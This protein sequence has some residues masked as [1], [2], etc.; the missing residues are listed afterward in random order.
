MG[1]LDKIYVE[2]R[3]GGDQWEDILPYVQE[4]DH[5]LW[6]ATD[7][8]TAEHGHGGSDYVMLYRL[9]QSLR[10][11]TPSD[12]DV[13]DAAAWSV[14]APLS[15]RSVANRSCPVDFPDFTRGAWKTR[16]PLGIV[17]A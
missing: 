4:F 10:T 6:K 13:Y 17:E 2:G 3:S 7:A 15:E 5:P 16:T 8:A 9:I 1:T 11:G 14:I 12:I